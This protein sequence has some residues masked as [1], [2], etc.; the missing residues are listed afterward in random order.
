MPAS[1][2]E[3]LNTTE[4]ANAL[5]IKISTI[6]AW[7]LNRRINYVKV[8]GSI[9]FLRSDIQKFIASRVVPAI[10]GKQPGMVSARKT[11]VVR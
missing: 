8:G 7:V 1:E 6:R 2:N 11:P 10:P 3:L 9:R 4:A 5:H